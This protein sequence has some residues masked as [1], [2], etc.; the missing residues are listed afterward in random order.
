MASFASLAAWRAVAWIQTC[1]VVFADGFVVSTQMWDCV[2]QSDA[3]VQHCLRWNE[4]CVALLLHS[5]VR[6]WVSPDMCSC[7]R[8][9]SWWFTLTNSTGGHVPYYAHS[10]SFL[11]VAAPFIPVISPKVS[12]ECS[13]ELCCTAM[14]LL[15]NC[16]PFGWTSISNLWVMLDFQDKFVLLQVVRDQFCISN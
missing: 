12:G 4:S 5:L 7:P 2:H 11:S 1:G 16:F 15:M 10:C 8:Q 6:P 3:P 14:V 13:V 9:I